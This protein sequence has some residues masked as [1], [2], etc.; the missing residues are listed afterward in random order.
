MAVSLVV[1]GAMLKG[2]A[3]A[4]YIDIYMRLLLIAPSA[5]KNMKKNCYEESSCHVFAHANV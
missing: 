1:T 5:T 3:L 4:M 2:L